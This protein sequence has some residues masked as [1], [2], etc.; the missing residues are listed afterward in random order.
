[1]KILVDTQVWLWMVHSP[2]RL[3]RSAKRHILA[4]RKRT[5][6]FGGECVGDSDQIRYRPTFPLTDGLSLTAR[7]SPAG[8]KSRSKPSRCPTRNGQ[9]PPV[10]ATNPDGVVTEAR[11]TIFPRTGSSWPSR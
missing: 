3:A 4:D 9:F 6:S 2:H 10:V 8:S 7:M 1:M 11:S 5:D